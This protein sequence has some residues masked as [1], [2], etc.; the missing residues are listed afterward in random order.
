MGL[1]RW[2]VA[3]ARDAT[4]SCA[5]QRNLT[6]TQ[7]GQYTFSLWRAWWEQREAGAKHVNNL[8]NARA[9]ECLHTELHVAPNADRCMHINIC[10]YGQRLDIA[11]Q[12]IYIYI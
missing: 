8:K 3:D 9:A 2:V 7:Y 6:G 1:H 12:S 4:S 10:T 5:H 11:S